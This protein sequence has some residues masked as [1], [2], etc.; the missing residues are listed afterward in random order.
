MAID[1]YLAAAE[2][3]ASGLAF[4]TL[5]FNLQVPRMSVWGDLIAKGYSADFDPER[6][7]SD[8]ADPTS[9]MG[10]PMGQT[11]WP[12]SAGWPMEQMP[13]EFRVAHASDVE[14]LIIN[15]NLDFST[16]AE[17]ATAELLPILPNGKEVILANMGHTEDL[18]NAQPEATAHLLRTYFDTGEV[19]S[20]KF[21]HQ[22]VAFEVGF[23]SFPTLGKALILVPLFFVAIISALLVWWFRRR[24]R[25]KRI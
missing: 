19:D 5:A 4:M 10:S 7:Y 21:T 8:L 6:D 2:G 18:W 3:D 1:A 22:P 16:P 20:S 25:Q 9:I 17:N 15:G 13:E 14:T 23:P 24:R 11:L 12:F